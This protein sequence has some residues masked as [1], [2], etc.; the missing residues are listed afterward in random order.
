MKE[1]IVL[2]FMVNTMKKIKKFIIILAL[3]YMAFHMLFLNK[4]I[5]DNSKTTACFIIDTYSKEEKA[6]FEILALKLSAMGLNIV[7]TR[8]CSNQNTIIITNSRSDFS[9]FHNLVYFFD[10]KSSKKSSHSFVPNNHT[11]FYTDKTDTKIKNRIDLKNPLI[12]AVT[13]YQD[14]KNK[15]YQNNYFRIALI[16]IAG[17]GNQIFNYATGYAYAK[18]YNKKTFLENKA[19]HLTNAFDFP[20]KNHSSADKLFYF[21]NFQ[22]SLNAANH[23]TLNKNLFILDNYG[24]LSFSYHQS[25]WNFHD[26]APEIQERLKFKAFTTQKNIKLAKKMQTENSVAIHIRLGD[27][28]TYQY[29]LLIYSNYY[30]NAIKYIQKH[31]PNPVFYVFTDDPHFVSRKFKPNI[32][33]TLVTG[34][35]GKESFRD[36]QLMSLCKHNIIANSTFSWWGAFLN[37][38]ENKIV[39]YPDRWLTV[40]H[41][42]LE[43]MRVPN[44]IEIPTEIT[45]NAN[46]QCCV[47]PIKKGL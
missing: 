4:T 32:P 7:K 30:E 23:S 44:W 31:V 20:E 16:P 11:V 17:L 42:W 9:Q 12:A 3:I 5:Q 35:T 26:F 24:T 19:S 22:N 10:F 18:R 6:F 1:A 43:Y 37:K 21:N 25:Y 45:N 36:M 38:N 15:K 29:P 40:D 47:Y 33:Y 13:V 27:Y 46:N 39:T 2:V 34:N 8:P 28:V 14:I 41:S